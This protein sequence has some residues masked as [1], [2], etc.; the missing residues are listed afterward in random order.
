[1]ITV[2]LIGIVLDLAFARLTRI[3]SV[4]WGFER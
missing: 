1:M 3:D 2:G 4:R